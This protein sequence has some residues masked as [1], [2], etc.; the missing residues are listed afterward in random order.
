[1]LF[2]E[3]YTTINHQSEAFP[4]NTISARC[5][6]RGGGCLTTRKDFRVGE[7]WDRLGELAPG[8]VTGKGKTW[9]LIK[10]PSGTYLKCK[11][12]MQWNSTIPLLLAKSQ[13]FS[14]S[15]LR[16]MSGLLGLFNPS[17]YFFSSIYHCNF[18]VILF[19]FHVFWFLDSTTWNGRERPWLLS[20]INDTVPSC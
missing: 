9:N 3:D 16:C 12:E 4:R 10:M 11:L 6:C 5:P 13:H 19:I 18:V 14:V 8:D 15:F 7:N 2:G 1:M 20:E 17:L